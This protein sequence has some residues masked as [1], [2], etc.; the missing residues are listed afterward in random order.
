MRKLATPKQVKLPNG[1]TFSAGY[2]RVNRGTLTPTNLRIRRT[3]TQSIR[4]RRQRQSRIGPRRQR[5]RKQQPLQQGTGIEDIKIGEKTANTEVGRMI[6][7]DTIGL[8]PKA[9]KKLKNKLF[10]KQKKSS[11]TSSAAPTKTSSSKETFMQI[12]EV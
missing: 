9:Y 2:E 11:K 3:Y 6:V 4:P 12:W 8:I 10:K 7:D 5:L 1:R